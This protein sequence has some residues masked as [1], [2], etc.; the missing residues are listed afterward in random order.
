M[1]KLLKRIV[2]EFPHPVFIFDRKYNLV[3]KNI[4]AKS[5]YY[6]FE[7]NPA[8]FIMSV[9]KDGGFLYKH[10]SGEYK[11]S[12]IRSDSFVIMVLTESK[13]SNYKKT[14]LDSVYLLNG[15]LD[16]LD[17]AVA[18]LNEKEETVFANT[19]FFSFTGYS[20]SE[21]IGRNINVISYKK[22]SNGAKYDEI[23][24][25]LKEKQEWWGEVWF[26]RKDGNLF[27][28][29][30]RFVLIEDTSGKY[31]VEI[32]RDIDK[33]KK[34][35]EYGKYI[36]LYNEYLDL[37]NEEF[38][39]QKVSKI[40]SLEKA[41]S[42]SMITLDNLNEITDLYGR[43]TGKK[44]LKDF[45]R[46]LKFHAEKK[47]LTLF[48]LGGNQF[49]LPSGET[50]KEKIEK[51][52]KD[53]LE[54][55]T[56]ER[57]FI[58]NYKIYPV[59]SAGITV[60]EANET[61]DQIF[62]KMFIANEFAKRNKQKITFFKAELKAEI[63]TKHNIK[64][65]I[66]RAFEQDLFLLHYQP[67]VSLKNMKITSAEALIRIST[68]KNKLVMPD[69]F[70]PVAEESDLINR[71]GDWVLKTLINEARYIVTK[72]EEKQLKF[73]FNLSANQ[74]LEPNL[75][76]KIEKVCRYSK[77]Y[78][79]I[80]EIEITEQA[81]MRDIKITLEKMYKLI[82]LGFELIIDDFGTGYSSLSYLKEF[83][84]SCLKID[85]VFTDG[86]PKEEK[87]V[88][89]VKSIIYL[90]KQLGLDITVEGV[91]NAEQF[92]WFKEH[93]CDEIQ[94]YYFSKPVEK[95]KFISLV[96]IFNKSESKNAYIKWEEGFSVNYTAFDAQ[97]MVIFNMLNLIYEEIHGKKDD[98]KSLLFYLD[99]LDEHVHVHFFEEENFMKNVLKIENSL[100]KKHVSMHEEFKAKI[101]VM[102]AKYASGKGKLRFELFELLKDWWQNHIQKEDQKCFANL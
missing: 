51:L 23:I 52:V 10:S 6:G 18:V 86:V 49:A 41:L 63:V 91:E 27:L 25:S 40:L 16:N 37:P 88:K 24:H 99:I 21:V 42:V 48:Y 43:K 47:G 97:H 62:D 98:D 70:I 101:A 2:N 69:E 78:E 102:R 54:K 85:K 84:V 44:F 17:E 83:P 95:E 3:L 66:E 94:G 46:K 93:N 80:F 4:I 65:L 26:E 9:E 58:N 28:T 30:C 82:D 75:V 59:V 38:L 96:K 15:I 5:F 81:L 36:K 60:S 12:V 71:I 90:A 45:S 73:S 87:T 7:R 92:R 67:R 1:M 77:D 29:L 39:K 55:I 50:D 11:C 8:S 14:F 19:K 32:F 57:F 22:L 100:L 61:Y 79:G 13:N 56:F 20:G 35:I 89:I 33:F 34:H 76:E 72:S 53:I 74:F 31:I 68:K 64:N